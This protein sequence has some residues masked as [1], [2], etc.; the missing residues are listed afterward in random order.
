MRKRKKKLKL[1]YLIFMI[2]SIVFLGTR[3]FLSSYN[4]NLSVTYQDN[5]E[6]ILELTNEIGALNQKLQS[7]SS[8]DRIIAVAL[9]E[10]MSPNFDNVVSVNNAE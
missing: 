4:V 2:S 3:T 6:K 5:Q 9:S 8:Y 10:N 1:P 7:L